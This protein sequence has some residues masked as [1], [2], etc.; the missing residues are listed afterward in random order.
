L[1]ILWLNITAMRPAGCSNCLARRK[2]AAILSSYE[3]VGPV[4]GGRGDRA[5]LLS[6][7]FLAVG[8]LQLAPGCGGA[9][10]LERLQGGIPCTGAL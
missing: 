6:G 5:R 2:T 3:L 8:F 7:A 10:V 1:V 9:G 4:G